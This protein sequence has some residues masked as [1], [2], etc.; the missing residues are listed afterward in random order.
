[1]DISLSAFL[2]LT[3]NCAPL[4]MH[5]PSSVYTLIAPL[6]SPQP[7]LVP[8]KDTLMAAESSHNPAADAFVIEDEVVLA[9][10][11]VTRSTVDGLISIV[12]SERVQALAA[13]NLDLTV[14]VKLLGR[15]IG[16][17][18]L[19]TRLLGLWKPTKAFWLM[20]IENEYFLVMF[21]SRVDYTKAISGGPWMLFGHYLVV[22]P[23]TVDFFTF[24]PH[25]NRVVAWIRLPGLLVTLHQKNMIMAIGK[26][27]GPVIKI[28]YQT[29]SGRR[30]CFA[31]MAI[32]IALRK[33]L[34]SKLLINGH[35]QVVEYES[36]P[37][38]CF[39]CGKYGH[40]RDICPTTG[41]EKTKDVAPSSGFPVSPAAPSP[42]EPFG[43][44]MKVERHQRRIV[45]KGSSSKAGS[46][47]PAVKGSHF[48]PLFEEDTFVAI[49]SLGDL[50]Q[51][52]DIVSEH[53]PINTES[54]NHTYVVHNSKG[55]SQVKSPPT[56]QRPL[57][58][59]E[60]QVP[61]SVERLNLGKSQAKSP[62]AKQR[63][64][65]TVQKPLS[66][67]RPAATPAFKPTILPTRHNSSLS[68]ARFA[69]FPRQSSRSSNSK[70]TAV[71]V[72]END[73][74]TAPGCDSLPEQVHNSPV[75]VNPLFGAV[76]TPNLEDKQVEGQALPT[77][78][79]SALDE[80]LTGAQLTDQ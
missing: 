40:V 45:R 19:R 33:P 14:V 7:G 1:M 39:E 48:N 67:Q 26:C 5:V 24:Q 32:S 43:P 64:P 53:V 31:R 46:S 36:L 4:G 51:Q 75:V 57:T 78:A 16:Y 60:P 59:T 34:V 70:N 6:S 50:P 47:D 77:T 41:T 69:P 65:T 25:S 66:V 30:G 68:S 76:M 13:K 20:D 44:W 74:P 27:I 35:L 71:V 12:F 8:Y 56:R 73:V 72:A 38:I 55:K 54:Q 29:E 42:D 22:E 3:L 23:W 10:G 63:S 28:D 9:D 61:T 58:I 52:V 49:A 2:A 11:D 37:T 15:R 18:T 17:N 62:P 79:V 21:K 80:G